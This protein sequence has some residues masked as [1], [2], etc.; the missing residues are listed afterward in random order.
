MEGVP[1]R[2]WFA[3]QS[4]GTSP[5]VMP[6]PRPT[7]LVF[8][9]FLAATARSAGKPNFL[10]IITDDQRPDT[11][12]AL[13][14]PVIRTPALDTLAGQGVVFT[15]AANQGAN[16]GAVCVPARAMINSGQHLWHV[17]EQLRGVVTL[18]EFFG[19]NGYDTFATGKWHNGNASVERSFA[20][21]RNITAGFLGKGHESEFA[22]LS[23][24]NGKTEEGANVAK[25]H[26]TDLIGATAVEF[27]KS[28]KGQKKPFLAYV[29][30]NAPHDPRQV[31]AVWTAPCRDAAGASLVPL[32]RNFLERPAFDH[33]VHA[34][35]DEVLLPT[36]RTPQAVR[37]E[38]AVYYGM[39]GQLDAQVALM[40]KALQEN[41]LWEDTIVVFTS[42]H[43]L[44]LGSHGLLGKQNVY[45]H[46]LRVPL[47]IRVP[48][49]KPGRND[50][51]TFHQDLYPT[52][53]DYA[54]L[55]DRLPPGQI[56]GRSLK[57]VLQGT[58]AAP[59][60]RAYHAY[61]GLHRALREGDWKLVEMEVK[62]VR[63]TQLF[64]LAKDPDEMSNLAERPDTAER[65]KTLREAMEA[66]RVAHGDPGLGEKK[67]R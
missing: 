51:L 62:G 2:M 23:V 56:D 31:P 26:S 35:R 24:E 66:E 57:P 54:G 52:L 9:L 27:L 13:G 50:A 43:G 59:R 22:T 67:K 58:G 32:P 46:S 17:K 63:T 6:V 14:N 40:F 55:A 48:A 7:F 1:D 11:L 8:L 39:V 41:G 36:P 42:D 47:I 25:V 28:R 45:E 3:I 60:S 18:G 33:G 37:E 21:S 64:D 53:A 15:R 30:F 12:G 34:I 61:T 20:R 5:P 49:Q 4:S 44:A 19:A 38:L 65:L 16:N 10:L 29:A